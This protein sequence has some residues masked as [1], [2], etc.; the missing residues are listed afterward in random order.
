MP[1]VLHAAG[2]WATRIPSMQSLLSFMIPLGETIGISM[3]GSVFSNKLG[4]DLLDIARRSP[5]L[6]LPASG[7]PN[8]DVLNNL[9]Q[10][11]KMEVQEAAARAVMWAL[12]SVLPF[13]GLSLVASV[14]LG[15]VWIGRAA[16]AA[17]EG[18][19][20]RE[21]EEGKVMYG[22]YLAALFTG[23][24]ST[25]KVD[26]DVNLGLEEDPR[27]HSPNGD[28]EVGT[29]RLEPSTRDSRRAWV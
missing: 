29:E 21:A 16:V 8:F 15:N 3:M 12:V 22:L 18:E 6:H 28:V 24:V 1:V 10:A 25:Q 5:S 23:S 17:K 2:I 27:K 19:P 13:V 20:G 4:I 11:A 26:L 9:P 14:F 7:L